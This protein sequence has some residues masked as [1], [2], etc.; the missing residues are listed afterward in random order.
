MR[1][2]FILARFALALLV[3]APLSARAPIVNITKQTWVR[4]DDKPL[5]LGQVKAAIIRGGLQRNW[6]AESAKENSLV[7][8]LTVRKHQV[9]VDVAFT[10]K[11]FSIT[12]LRSENMDYEKD[13]SGLETIHSKYNNWIRNL[14]LDIQKELMR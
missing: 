7:L 12:Y 10:E 8:H 2:H 3:V 4:P 5:T 1:F 11:D 9:W 13:A 14:V 6:M